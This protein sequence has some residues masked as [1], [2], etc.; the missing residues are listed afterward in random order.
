MANNLIKSEADIRSKIVLGDLNY[1]I[2]L[3]VL[4]NQSTYK[5]KIQVSFDLGAKS[6]L[7]WL[8]FWG[9][10]VSN[11]TVNGKQ[12]SY[13]FSDDRIKLEQMDAGDTV[14]DIDFVSKFTNRGVGIHHYQDK[15]TNENFYYSNLCPYDAHRIFPCFDQP[16]LK[17]C[18]ELQ[19]KCLSH[20][21]VV[22]NYPAQSRQFMGDYQVV[23][24]EKTKKFSTYLFNVSFGDYQK[25]ECSS[26]KIPMNIL[27]RKE[28]ESF[29]DHERI[30]HLIET[31][32]TF[33]EEFFSC[34]FPFPKY[35]QIF[36]PEF[37]WGAMENIGAVVIREEMLFEEV[38]KTAEKFSRANTLVH[39][40]AHMWFGN[41]V[42]MKWW[43][44][45]W[46]NESFATYMAYLCLEQT[47]LYGDSFEYFSQEVKQGAIFEDAL[48][49][50]HPVVVDCKDTD[51]AFLNFDAITYL[52]GASIL[53]QLV[54]FI[55]EGGFKKGLGKYFAKYAYANTSLNDFLAEFDIDLTGFSKSWLETCGTNSLDVS[56]T[57]SGYLLTQ[58]YGGDLEFRPRKFQTS[59]FAQTSN[60]EA[61]D[62]KIQN[63]ETKELKVDVEHRDFFY[64][65]VGDF[66][67]V[68]VGLDDDSATYLLNNISMIK[69]ST[70]A[71]LLHNSLYQMTLDQKMSVEDYYK[72]VTHIVEKSEHSKLLISAV[73]NISAFVSWGLLEEY[74]KELRAL[75]LSKINSEDL[76]YRRLVF[77]CI[78]RLSGDEESKQL[79][80][81][82][83][84]SWLAKSDLRKL[85]FKLADSKFQEEIVKIC[86]LDNSDSGKQFLEKLRMKVEPDKSKSWKFL[87]EE[88]GISDY[89]KGEAMGGFFQKNEESKKFV[90]KYFEYLSKIMQE[91]G[92]IYQKRYF[93]TLF[94]DCFVKESLEGCTETLK[95]SNLHD[96]VV[97][98]ITR[99]RDLLHLRKKLLEK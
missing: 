32:M 30:F 3:D 90:P 16:D 98:Q 83:N 47:G 99:W 11:L 25:I 50:T 45:L 77:S 17:A 13:I 24:F 74:K 2:S 61:K 8:D 94:P 56:K 75:L 36:V 22:A 34:K 97:R 46:L 9:E 78:L 20:Y 48:S 59:S 54:F 42:T 6:D 19:L 72:L 73:S 21:E 10:E 67:Y 80:E 55:G 79:W 88:N 37:N 41:L 12:H 23:Q 71:I 95:D 38:P 14:I 84:L 49:T 26:S 96:S 66:D 35:D 58:N 52:K 70:F 93:T 15:N 92:N 76:D 39:E 43:D 27:Y 69:D 33:Y 7:L 68:R 81:M 1:K 85:Y 65:N 91:K 5:G 64:P 62:L 82:K 44:D 29:V 31:A 57:D 28:K 51:S 87:I 53:K 60:F 4:E 40:L 86:E 18:Y 89:I 63:Q